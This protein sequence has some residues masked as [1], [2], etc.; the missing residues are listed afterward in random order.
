MT[1]FLQRL[2]NGCIF[3]SRCNGIPEKVLKNDR[4]L[5]CFW[6]TAITLPKQPFSKPNT[7]YIN[8]YTKIF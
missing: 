1:G 2:K 8:V 6:S 5:V 3:V 4:I 7:P